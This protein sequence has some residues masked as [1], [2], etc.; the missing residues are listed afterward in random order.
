[1]KTILTLDEAFSPEEFEETESALFDMNKEGVY[2]PDFLPLA[3]NHM[4]SIEA[5]EMM[6]EV[7]PMAAYKSKKI[8]FQ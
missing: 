5:L 8:T 2:D 1:M 3:K 6:E 7:M 4:Y